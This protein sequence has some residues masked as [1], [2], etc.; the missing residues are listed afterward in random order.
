MPQ[1]GRPTV[2]D[3]FATALESNRP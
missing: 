2:R 3:C 1:T